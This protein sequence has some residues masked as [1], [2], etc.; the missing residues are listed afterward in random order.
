MT[1]QVC[2]IIR[3]AYGFHS[4][5]VAL[6][7][8]LLACGPVYL[9][10]SYHTLPPT[11]R[12]VAKNARRRSAGCPGWC[13]VRRAGL[14]RPGRLS[15]ACVDV[16][17][18]GGL[19]IWCLTAGTSSIDVP[20]RCRAS[21][22]WPVSGGLGRLGHPSAPPSQL[23]FGELSRGSAAIRPVPPHLSRTRSGGIHGTASR[24]TSA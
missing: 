4:P 7:T 15:P 5:E 3:R 18:N 16:W 1:H 22:T 14:S 10:L 24:T 12:A 6:A 11:C 2:L 19:I 23:R 20:S 13:G 21:L 17:L 9:K 8:F